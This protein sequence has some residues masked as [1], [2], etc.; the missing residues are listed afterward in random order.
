MP[1]FT[2]LGSRGLGFGRNSVRLQ[3]CYLHDTATQ[4]TETPYP[5]L[6]KSSYKPTRTRVQTN[7]HTQG[8]PERQT[9]KG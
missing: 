8:R 7:T 3:V 2:Q 6:R 4:H 1:K 5:S 9:P